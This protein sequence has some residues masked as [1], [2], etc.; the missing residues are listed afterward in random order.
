MSLPPASSENFITPNNKY[1]KPSELNMEL[2]IL[3]QNNL[4]NKAPN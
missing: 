1:S 3:P 2:L 4:R